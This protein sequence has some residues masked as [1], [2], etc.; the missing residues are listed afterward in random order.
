MLSPR[1]R[2][3]WI[4]L[5]ADKVRT[6]LVTVSIAV[7]IFAVGVIFGAYVLIPAGLNSS[8]SA[9]NPANIIMST[10][11]FDED[12]LEAVRRVP[13]VAAAEGQRY[14]SV[15]MLTPAGEWVR[16]DLSARSDIQDTQVNL[17]WL[18]KG[19]LHPSDREFLLLKKT[20]EK[21]GI[22]VGQML[23]IEL[24]DGT[25]KSGRVVGTVRE[26]TS[27]E[28]GVLNDSAGFVTSGSLEW[29]H[30]RE[31]YGSLY[32][33]VSEKPN[34]R[35]HIE[36]VAQAVRDRVEKSGLA[37]YGTDIHRKDRHPL[38]NIVLAILNVLALL[39]VL[40]VFLSTALVTNTLAAL[41]SQHLRYIGIMKLIGAQRRQ[42]VGMY[43]ALILGYSA[44]ALLLAVPF[45]GRAAYA[46]SGLVAEMINFILIEPP[47]L[48]I[49]PL[50][51]LV[52]LAMA[53]FIPLL[54]GAW[55]IIRGSRIT[56]HRAITS[57]GVNGEGYERTWIQR[58]MSRLTA[59]PR[60]L[61]ISIRNT[62]RRRGRVALT[63]FTLALGGAIFIAVFT[64]RASVNRTVQRAIGYFRADVNLDFGMLYRVDE[65][66]RELMAISGVERV[67]AWS[68]TRAEWLRPDGTAIGGI[69]I[70]APPS[71]SI[72]VK[73]VLLQ[74]R[75]L[76]P[77]DKGAIAVN[78]SF[79][80][81]RPD[82]K[83]GDTLRLKI[84]ERE[85]D[86]L[87][88]GIFQFTGAEERYGFISYEFLNE[89]QKLNNRA[90]SFRIRS[91][92]HS[93]AGQQELAAHIDRHFR[94]LGYHV[95]SVEAG[96]ALARTVSDVLRI[97]IIVLFVNASLTAL[98]GSIGL[99]GTLGMNV[100]ER[101]REIGVMRAIGAHDGIVMRLV[102][103]EGLLIGLI[104]FVFAVL[105]SFPIANVLSD[106]INLAI[107][108]TRTPATFTAEGVVVWFIVVVLLSIASSAVPARNASR[109]TIRE[110]LAYE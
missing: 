19:E 12:L 89:V 16:L 80:A 40:L 56:V 73:P 96:G 33:T 11:A 24:A 10:D 5:W 65:V 3:V 29:L 26:L 107:F 104:S 76:A 94:S 61:L 47:G 99:A 74:G 37:V 75:W 70:L 9:S 87:V 42:I 45:A 83:P 43:L 53:V 17:L 60:P 30:Q 102:L 46:V 52:Q 95:S 101:T 97:L 63:L 67:E 35:H 90:A 2:K 108:G 7:G 81:E 25:R 15:R 82:L 71:D 32:V 6:M 57:V 79:W 38:S 54:A 77:G 36:A 88:V 92:D 64:V 58:Q 103:G 84:D 66:E 49:I 51:L 20:A 55:P 109:M 1:W 21:Y 68:G 93:L 8:Y 105:I 28:R 23:E 34:D 44:L 98:V 69:T 18:D 86:W 22:L 78:E 110:V 85:R 59:V 41:L 14:V 13:G 106:T 31:N 4:D 62:F 100:L 27:G 48:P 50:A 91:A 72:L 39:G